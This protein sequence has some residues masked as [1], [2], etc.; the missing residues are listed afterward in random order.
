MTGYFLRGY[1]CD[2]SFTR[3]IVFPGGFMS[4]R[5]YFLRGYIHDRLFPEGVISLEGHVH[6]KLFSEGLCS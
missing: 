1:D 2:G 3:K 5:D 4:M 6:D